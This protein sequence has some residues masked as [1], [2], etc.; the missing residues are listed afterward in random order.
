MARNIEMN[1]KTSD[2]SYEILYPMT[3]IEQVGNLEKSLNNFVTK[4]S[5]IENRIASYFQLQSWDAI[6]S[7]LQSGN[8]EN[9]VIGSYKFITL[10]GTAGPFS[11][12][13]IQAYAVIIGINHNSSI[14]G[15]NR[16]HLQI[17]LNP[18]N[19]QTLGRAS[20]NATNTNAGGWTSSYMRQIVCS[21]FYN[22]LPSDLRS[23][24]KTTTKYTSAGSQST[25][26]ISSSDRIFLLSE[27]EV[28][29]A[30][31]NSASG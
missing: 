3:T 25:S 9:Y 4:E 10:N 26:I 14:E 8:T 24:V 28:F 18:E 1:Y 12:N 17:S 6:N 23:V 5:L 11:F 16:L 19:T 29:G 15:N 30:I 21:Q 13:N 2:G 20:M 31:S 27:F 22:C 7:D